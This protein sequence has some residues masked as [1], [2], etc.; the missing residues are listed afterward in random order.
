MASKKRPSEPDSQSV[1]KKPRTLQKFLV[2]YTTDWP[3]LRPSAKG[4]TF[5]YCETC[6]FDFSIGHGGRDDCKRHVA[7]K[8]HKEYAALRRTCPSVSFAF[9]KMENP[10]SQKIT[11]AEALL[12]STLADNNL[13]FAAADKLMKTFKEMFPG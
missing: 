10:V 4:A 3:V 6:R 5:C 1:T 7:S 8:R 12:V 9:K 11:K 2:G 13:P